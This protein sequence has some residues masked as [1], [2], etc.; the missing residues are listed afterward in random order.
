MAFDNKVLT[1]ALARYDADKTERRLRFER[2]REEIFAKLPHVRELDQ[3]IRKAVID[4]AA[5]AIRRKGELKQQI[6][7]IASENLELQEELVAE[8]ERGGYSPRALD[9]LPDCGIC[10]DRGFTR[11]S[12]CECLKS[13]YRDEQLKVLGESLNTTVCR[14]DNFDLSL[15]P[16]SSRAIMERVV[17]L[18]KEYAGSFTLR[19]RNLYL[20]GGPG[21]G[22]TFISG[23]IAGA[24]TELGYSVVYTTA[25]KF[26]ETLEKSKF[27][28]NS[29]TDEQDDAVQRFF[30]SDLL[31]IDDLGTEMRTQFTISAIYDVI[32]TRIASALPTIITSNYAP[33]QLGAAYSPQIE[34]R[35]SY[36]Y[37]PCPFAGEDIRKVKRGR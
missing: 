10:G 15:Y 29:V 13:V 23:C 12:M 5:A 16:A 31:I 17:Q 26:C 20:Y 19:S 14:F 28:R 2:E 9:E 27:A 4:A 25:V 3:K 8:L 21:L 37:I 33:N 6:D 36:E 1:R 11:G 24:V 32:N 30:A 34:S 7:A 35:L 22:K 18:C